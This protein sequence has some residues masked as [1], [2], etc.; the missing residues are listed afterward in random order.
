MLTHPDQKRILTAAGV[1]LTS[2]KMLCRPLGALKTFSPRDSLPPI[3][4]VAWVG[5]PAIHFGREWKRINWFVEAIRRFPSAGRVALL[6]DALDSAY[7]ALGKTGRECV[8][9]SRAHTALE[10]YP[11]HYRTFDCVVVTSISEAGPICLFEALASGVPIISTRVGWAPQLIRRGENGFLVESIEG[12]V[13]AL[14]QIS[15]NRQEWFERRLAIRESLG[16]FTIEGWVDACLE[17]ARSLA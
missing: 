4:T 10:A 14:E 6:G 13:D 11:A 9:H 5:R 12:V 3:F 17:L 15:R 1:D 16:G 7:D 8:Y 2:K